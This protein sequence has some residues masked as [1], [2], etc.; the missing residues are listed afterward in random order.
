[1]S[2][3]SSMRLLVESMTLHEGY[4]ERIAQ[5]AQLV[6]GM[7]KADILAKI[8]SD[9]SNAQYGGGSELLSAMPEFKLKSKTAAEAKRDLIAYM[10]QNK[11]LGRAKSTAIR[12]PYYVMQRN[13]WGDHKV[14]VSHEDVAELGHNLLTWA[15]ESFPDGDPNDRVSEWMERMD[16]DVGDGYD[17]IMPIACKKYLGTK[18]YS[19]YLAQLW[20]DVYGDRGHYN[21]DLTRS[22]GTTNPWR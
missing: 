12:A 2:L 13:S 6:K 9:L 21:D 22:M 7:S 8:D 15:G 1:M 3:T 20:D 16:W 4:E 14:P 18:N 10:S 5:A 11:L 17:R 19:E